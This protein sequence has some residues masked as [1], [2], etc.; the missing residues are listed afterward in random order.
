M[1]ASH[2]V[3]MRLCSVWADS[4]DHACCWCCLR[5]PTAKSTASSALAEHNPGLK[6]QYFA[7]QSTI[8]RVQWNQCFVCSMD[9]HLRRLIHERVVG[10]F[11]PRSPVTVSLLRSLAFDPCEPWQ[12][13]HFA[14]HST[15]R[16]CAFRA[17]PN[18]HCHSSVGY[19]R[20]R[21]VCHRLLLNNSLQFASVDSS[22]HW[23]IA[24]KRTHLFANGQCNHLTRINEVCE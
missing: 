20:P 18:Q 22:V 9:H 5:R 17:H 3:P 15:R 1:G 11:W 6:R 10:R 23:P 4:V 14:C 8:R 16:P 7:Y 12:G 24:T 13:S 19:L 2:P 21:T